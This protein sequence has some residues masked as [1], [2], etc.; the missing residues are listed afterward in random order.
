MSIKCSNYQFCKPGSDILWS[1]Q[2]FELQYWENKSD[3]WKTKN[4]TTWIRVWTACLHKFLKQNS[5]YSWRIS[6]PT[7]I[8]FLMKFRGQTNKIANIFFTRTKMEN[9]SPLLPRFLPYTNYVKLSKL[10]MLSSKSICAP[11]SKIQ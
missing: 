8:H 1:K 6:A 9:L 2:T 3:F 10:K 11:P 7:K 5:L 4:R